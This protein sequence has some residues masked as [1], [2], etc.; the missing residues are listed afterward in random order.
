MIFY[1]KLFYQIPGTTYNLLVSF[2]NSTINVYNYATNTSLGVYYKP[3]VVI[4]DFT[5]INLNEFAFV[6]T[7]SYN[8]KLYCIS[9][10]KYD[11]VK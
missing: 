10:T 4:K 3:A 5:Y 1:F 6:S 11:S 2:S 7:G 9:Y 8:I